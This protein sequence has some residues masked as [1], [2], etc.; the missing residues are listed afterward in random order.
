MTAHNRIPLLLCGADRL[1]WVWSCRAEQS[2]KMKMSVFILHARLHSDSR[3]IFPQ[4]LPLSRLSLI[5]LSFPPATRASTSNNE[6]QWVR[7]HSCWTSGWA[8]WGKKKKWSRQQQ[9][10]F[11][12]PILN[13]LL[14]CCC[15]SERRA[16]TLAGNS[17]SFKCGWIGFLVAKSVL[18]AV[19]PRGTSHIH[20][21]QRYLSSVANKEFTGRNTNI[22]ARA[23]GDGVQN[24]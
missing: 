9:I 15:P 23:Q 20:S 18:V 10:C 6:F 19:S 2:V 11:P 8:L 5:W 12:L 17:G 24:K 13:T 3:T 1:Q 7:K 14:S 22:V 21:A 16:Q 4:L